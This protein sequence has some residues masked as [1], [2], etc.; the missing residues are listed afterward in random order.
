MESFIIEGGQSLKGSIKPQGAKNEALQ[1]L[2][3]TLL[4]SEPIIV[5]NIPNILDVNKLIKILTNLGVEIEKISE[6]SFR[7][8]SNNI[9]LDYLSSQD[10]KDDGQRL[11][12]SIMIV[13][14]LLARF[15]KG[16][17][18][19]PGGDKIGRRRLDTHFESFKKLGAQFNYDKK[20]SFFIFSLIL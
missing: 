4:T 1:I 6:G 18:P 8:R 12:G 20:E 15:G 2:C 10:F 11:R 19:R 7:F 3:A 14:P 13:G 16:S 17:V 9:N 5:N